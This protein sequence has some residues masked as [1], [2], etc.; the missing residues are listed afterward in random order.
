MNRDLPGG[1]TFDFSGSVETLGGTRALDSSSSVLSE[2]S[3]VSNAGLRRVC[4]GNSSE[5]SF[6]TESLRKGKGISAAAASAAAAKCAL[7]LFLSPEAKLM[8]LARATLAGPGD[9]PGDL[10]TAGDWD[11][12]GDLIGPTLASGDGDLRDT[13]GRCWPSE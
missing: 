4:G 11:D 12:P 1:A 8:P 9:F 7:S 3:S 6:F 5:A 10:A 2:S 13:A